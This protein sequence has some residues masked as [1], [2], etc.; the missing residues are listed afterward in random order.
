MAREG[1]PRRD[2]VAQMRLARTF[3]PRK[4]AKRLAQHNSAGDEDGPS[5]EW[6]DGPREQFPQKHEGIDGVESPLLPSDGK[7]QVY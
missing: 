5:S 2:A 4:S 1:R 3:V 6:F 7:R